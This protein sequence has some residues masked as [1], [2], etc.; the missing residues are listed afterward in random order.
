M[1]APQEAVSLVH[2]LPGRLRVRVAAIKDDPAVA[3][4]FR[5]FLLAQPGVTAVRL[6][7]W[8]ASAVVGYDPAVITPPAL[9]GAAER[10]VVSGVIDKQSTPKVPTSLRAWLR[11]GLP[12][13]FQAIFGLA[14]F[15]AGLFGAPPPLTYALLG[16]AGA[17]IVG[18]A[19]RTLYRQRRASIDALDA[20]AGA[21]MLLRGNL[22]AA[23]FMAALIGLGEYIRE[24][25]A[26]RS[27]E[28]LLDLLG[29]SG[30]AAWVVRGGLKVRVAADQVYLGEV[31]VVYPGDRVPVDGHVLEGHALV[32]QRSLT[33]EAAP[34]EKQRG[35][36]VFASTVLVEG[37]LYLR[38]E[39]VGDE[40]RAGRVIEA[41]RSVPLG[42]TRIENYAAKLAD[43]LVLPIFG[44]ALL[45]YALSRE[46][47][48]A[49][50]LLIIDFG[51]GV[52][53]AAPTAVLAAMAHAAHRGIL[54]KSGASIEKLSRV[55]AVVFDKTGTLTRGEPEVTDVISLLPSVAPQEML[56]LAAAAEL[57]LRHPAAHAIIRRARH[58]GCIIPERS[59]SDYLLGLGVR[60]EVDGQRMHVGSRL[61]MEQMGISLGLADAPTEAIMARAESIVYV[62]RDGVLTGLIAYAD[63][64]RPESAEVVAALRR[65]GV[66]EVLMLTGDNESV[67]LA[68]ATQVGIGQYQATVFPN[69]KAEVVRRLQRAGRT[70]AVVGDG[71]NDSPALVHADVAVS[72]HAGTDVARE[73]A[74]VV[75]TDDDLRR[76]PEAMSIASDAMSV[77]RE[78]LAIVVVP[79]AIGLVLAALGRIGPA[80]AT[81]ANNGSTVVA[82][83]NSLRPLFRGPV[84]QESLTLAPPASPSAEDRALDGD[85]IQPAVAAV[86]QAR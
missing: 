61:F 67:A 2:S 48:R 76:L 6:N 72:L 84:A 77:L 13:K 44:S 78:N 74:D 53:I 60:A 25:T 38:V 12:A 23:G 7:R 16:A 1:T 64:P 35:E 47:T 80:G 66:K 55:D 34:I 49:I 62:A 52:R 29:T 18:R 10:A 37:K 9:A 70:V 32:D 33:G 86:Q 40:T 21:L 79:N 45:A 56:A 81:L 26:R 30:L 73:A 5:D 85:P 42:E 3:E 63:P 58:D 19:A 71:I 8:C 4:A 11:R 51:T 22:V 31:V 75:L 54:I 46:I 17:A 39:A 20:T 50:S 24:R 57:R 15:L 27:R 36:A 83:L 14:S 68:T 69:Q 43:R 65:R 41:V 82:A 28:L 59:Q